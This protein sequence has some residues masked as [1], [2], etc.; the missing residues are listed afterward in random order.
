[1]MLVKKTYPGLR[2]IDVIGFPKLW[3]NK[4]VHGLVRVDTRGFFAR[5][6]RD[7][8]YCVLA[9]LARWA[10]GGLPEV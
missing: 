6:R 9:E 10:S 2:A 8:I 3:M 1:M 4:D 5:G 7:G